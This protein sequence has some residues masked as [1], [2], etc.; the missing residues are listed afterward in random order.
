MAPEENKNKKRKGASD[1]S[2]KA[3]KLKSEAAAAAKKTSKALKSAVAPVDDVAINTKVTRKRTQSIFNA[4]DGKTESTKD[5]SK[6]A[7]KTKVAVDVTTVDVE[8]TE[9]KPEVAETTPAKAKKQKKTKNVDAEAAAPPIADTT[10]ELAKEKTGKSKRNKA[11]SGQAV[12]TATKNVKKGKGAVV[13]ETSKS[14]DGKKAKDKT[15]KQKPST[16]EADDEG[17]DEE[18]GEDDQTAALLAGFES[19]DDEADPAEDNDFDAENLKPVIP[20]ALRGELKKA[21]KNSAEPGVVF[22]GRVPHGFY[23]QQM[24]AYFSQFGEVTKLRLA[25]NKKTGQSKHFA[26]VEFASAEV[27]DI[28]AQTMDKYLLFGHI[29]QCKVI[30]P[31]SVHPE[32]FKGANKRFKAI[33]HSK[34]VYAEANRGAERAVWEKRIAQ[35]ESRRKSMNKKTKELFDYEY[36]APP[37]KSVDTVPKKIL[38]VEPQSEPQLLAEAPQ[39]KEAE[40]VVE[41]PFEPTVLEGAKPKKSKKAHKLKEE[42]DIQEELAIT[43]TPIKEKKVKKAKAVKA[44]EPEIVKVDETVAEADTQKP[45]KS[46]KAKDAA[47]VV[48]SAK[49][50]VA[51]ADT[52][53]QKKTK[54][55]KEVKEVEVVVDSP[56]EKKTKSKKGKKAKDTTV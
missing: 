17:S 20:S 50:I 31:S 26:F 56:K 42:S 47:V 30:P 45:K 49:A 46:K 3:K 16:V 51:D 22:V 12:E 33:P 55:V 24:K 44:A 11:S 48:E 39:E 43:A 7:K 10:A 2:P 38:A 36:E 25:R 34:M 40:P 1:A 6:K 52:P 9:A 14:T 18:A 27:A 4:E 41:A 37:L 28:V 8:M 13:D 53:K 35:E 15:P 19:S 29:L 54:K 32:L 21:N 5:K 23:E